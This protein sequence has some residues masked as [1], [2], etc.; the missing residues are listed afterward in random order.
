MNH[1]TL[2]AIQMFESPSLF[3]YQA[4]Y[5][6]MTET[7]NNKYWGKSILNE[8]RFN[9]EGKILTRLNNLHYHIQYSRNCGF[10]SLYNLQATANSYFD[11]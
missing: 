11:I 5:L 7:Y 4:N 2:Q 10:F 8:D 6:E 1:S 3:K 9:D